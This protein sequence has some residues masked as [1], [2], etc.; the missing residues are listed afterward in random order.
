MTW[1]LDLDGVVW[2]AGTGIPGSA[3]AVTEL[4][5]AGERVIFLTNN[6]GP[7]VAEHMRALAGV[8]IE[9]AATDLATSAQAA[10]SMLPEGSRAA[11]VGGEGIREALVARGVV[12]VGARE[13]PDAVVVGRTVDLDYATL[14][15]A[16]TAVREGARFVA[17]NTDATF[18][19][20]GS[21]DGLVP[22]AGAIVAFVA[23]A[24]GCRPE[25]AGKPHE[26]LAAL[27]RARYGPLNVVAGDRPDTDGLF[28]RLVGAQF[29]LV[30]SGVTSCSDLPVDPV[31]AFVADD[32]LS[33]VRGQLGLDAC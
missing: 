25:V 13:Q 10:A 6:S 20:G 14:G 16:A 23:T 22:G 1:A 18:P 29:G 31:P 12:V 2:L 5:Q 4:R 26:T 27:V 15:A 9:C 7:L 8:G 24:S 30:L 3:Q 19:T 17:T 32:L 28:A 33:L 21:T 11:F